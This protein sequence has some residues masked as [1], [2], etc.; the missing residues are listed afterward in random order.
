MD[1]N[2]ILNNIT[3]E[4]INDKLI[5]TPKTKEE[6]CIAVKLWCD[7]RTECEKKFGIIGNWN[8][9]LIT[10]MENLFS[11]YDNFNDD[12]SNWNVSNVTN[13]GGMFYNAKKFNQDLSLW[14]VSNVKDMFY[15]FRNSNIEVL[16]EWYLDCD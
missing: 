12:I 3:V 1:I 2:K 9:M 5:F 11:H 10:D 6:L 15:M 13:M 7:F 8:T 16:P 14:D 4:N